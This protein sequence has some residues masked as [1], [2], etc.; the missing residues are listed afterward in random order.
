MSD[1]D[2]PD[3]AIVRRILAGDAGEFRRLF[4]ALFPRLYRFALTRTGGDHA[5]AE[6]AVQASFC[7]AIERLDSYRGEAALFTW[8]CR[9]CRNTLADSRRAGAATVPIEDHPDVRALLEALAAP[10]VDQPEVAAWTGE[11]GRFVQVTVDALPERYGQVLE[12]KYVDGASVR[13]IAARLGLGEKAAESLLTRARQEFRAL[14]I[15]LAQAG[16]LRGF[17]TYS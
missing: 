2:H 3:L 1:S 11:L 5:A 4:D 16:E 7:K 9:I 15:E 17:T 14:F 6:E 10:A 13:E 8:L 12:W